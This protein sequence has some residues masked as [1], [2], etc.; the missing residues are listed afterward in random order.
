MEIPTVLFAEHETS[1]FLPKHNAVGRFKKLVEVYSLFSCFEVSMYI[2]EFSKD[3][4][5]TDKFPTFHIMLE[6]GSPS[7]VHCNLV[8]NC[9]S[10]SGLE[11]LLFNIGGT[12]TEN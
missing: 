1:K 10:I 2:V 3:V 6:A 5:F 9:R 8:A 12:G 7:Y 4:S 11:A